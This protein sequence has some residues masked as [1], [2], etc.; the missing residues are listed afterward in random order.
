MFEQLYYTYII[1]Y[2]SVFFVFFVVFVQKLT[3]TSL[4]IRAAIHFD[5]GRVLLV[6]IKVWREDECNVKRIHV[7]F[8]IYD[9]ECGERLRRHLPIIDL[10]LQVGIVRQ[11]HVEVCVVII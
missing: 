1:G 5:E 2:N 9:V 6:R 7:V 11:L 8:L 4:R 10:R 3:H